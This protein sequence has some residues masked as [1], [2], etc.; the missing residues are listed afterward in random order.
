[1]WEI[2][3]LLET[4]DKVLADLLFIQNFTKQTM[5]VKKKQ[6]LC[7]LLYRIPESIFMNCR[8]N[9]LYKAIRVRHF[10]SKNKAA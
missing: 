2:I 8:K 1:M 6:L 10:Y 4:H 7:N 5:F 3:K 9:I